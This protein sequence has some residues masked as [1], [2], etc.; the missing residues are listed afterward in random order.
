MSSSDPPAHVTL[1]AR[2][3]VFDMDGLLVDS[4]PLWAAVEGDFA[5]VRGAEFTAEHAAS[6]VGRGLA[7]TLRFMNATFG[8]A[9]DLERDARDIVDRFLSRARELVL[10][11]GALALLDAAAAER[12]P[13][14]LGSSSD[15]RL[16]KAVVAAVGVAD[17]FASVVAGDDVPRT[18]PAPDIFLECALDLGVEPAGCVVLEDSVAGVLAGRAAAMKVIAVPERYPG[19]PAL[20]DSADVVVRDLFAA[21]RAIRFAGGGPYTASK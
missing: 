17:R 16:V 11:P 14:A 1:E 7:N 2:A 3:I 10:M 4:E 21:R 8:F 6:C 15:R 20:A 12:V 19:D 18:K 13:V 5:R 9:V